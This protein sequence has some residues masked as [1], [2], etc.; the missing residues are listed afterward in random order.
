M[1]EKICNK[2]LTKFSSLPI[3]QLQPLASRNLKASDA[4]NLPSY[5]VFAKK[6]P[7]VLLKRHSF[8]TFLQ[9]TSVFGLSEAY[10][11]SF[12]FLQK[13]RRFSEISE[14]SLHEKC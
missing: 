12:M 4:Y 14:T 3:H 8:E 13:S 10:L 2:K 1:N 6:R 11:A 9:K 5:Y 7:P